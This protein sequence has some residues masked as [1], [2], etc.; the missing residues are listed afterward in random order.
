MN[1]THFLGMSGVDD[2]PGMMQSR[3]SQPPMT[4]PEWIS[5]SSLSGIDI[6][7]STVQGLFTWPEMLNSLVPAINKEAHQL[8]LKVNKKN[9]LYLLSDNPFQFQFQF[10]IQS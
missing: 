3:L 1:Q 7:S 10:F 4:P 5:I 6:S 9:R 8:K 2:P